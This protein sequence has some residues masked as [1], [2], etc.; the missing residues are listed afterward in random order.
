MMVPHG[1]H[2]SQHIA[3]QF[4]YL[5]SPEW[6]STVHGLRTQKKSCVHI[7]Q[8]YKHN[9]QLCGIVDQSHCSLN[10]PR[11]SDRY[12]GEFA[13]ACWGTSL[14]FSAPRSKE[15]LGTL[16]NHR[17]THAHTHVH[18][19]SA[20][21]RAHKRTHTHTA[22]AHDTLSSEGVPFLESGYCCALLANVQMRSKA[23]CVVW[24]PC[25][26]FCR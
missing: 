6:Y 22:C 13:A 2:T 7:H 21:A 20:L 19:H 18:T 24:T 11:L 26:E 14:V 10:Q 16:H 1:T 5:F 8:K 12:G 15:A 9:F 23:A 17:H 25:H 4:V 3:T